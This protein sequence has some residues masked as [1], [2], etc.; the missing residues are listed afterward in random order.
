M[1]DT[2]VAD[3]LAAQ[4]QSISP[5][6]RRRV[7]HK[8]LGLVIHGAGEEPIGSMLKHVIREFFPLIRARIDKE[9]GI[10]TKPVD[11]GDPAEVRIWFRDRNSR[12]R[13]ELRVFE[14]WW[15][16]AFQPPAFGE[17][18]L[19]LLGFLYSWLR[20][21]ERRA[22][23]WPEWRHWGFALWERIVVDVLV[24]LSLPLMVPLLVYLWLPESLARRIVPKWLS[25]VHR[26][27]INIVTRQLGDMLVYLGQ[28][29]EASRVRLRFEERFYQ[30]MELMDQDFPKVDAVFIIAYSTG[31]VV[32]YEALTGRQLTDLIENK[33][34]AK[35]KPTLH[36]I[37]VGSGLNIAWDFAPENERFR[38]CRELAR[39]V[40]WLDLWG[41]VDPVPRGA[42]RRPKTEDLG[43]EWLRGG[44]ATFAT[45][46]VVNQ[47]DV[48]SDHLTY[49]NNAEEVIAPILDTITAKRLSSDLQMNVKSR[50]RRVQLLALLKSLAWLV[51]PVVYASLAL[52]G[53]GQRISA[54]AGGSFLSGDAWHRYLLSPILWSAIGA[55][56]AVMLYSSV[57][58]WAW[59]F[60]DRRVKYDRPVV[61]LPGGS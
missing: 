42:P 22:P 35:G 60:W 48:F 46:D 18:V 3:N 41:G 23:I 11:E 50:R 26:W 51:G 5:F 56:G 49:W 32:S 45:H 20:H 28:P 30:L 52:S 16:Q 40:H 59:D 54:W 29:L 53:G 15:T 17:C 10:A 21:P 8:L 7:D 33:F 34:Q 19:G 6:E 2:A 12:E 44:P 14:V 58:K 43:Q 25:G 61:R 55:A 39:P 31:A 9:A 57:V 24:V 47:T 37:T 4:A 27:L 1:N 13:Y 36:Y 38:F